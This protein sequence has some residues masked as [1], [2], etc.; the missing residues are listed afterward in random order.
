MIRM[1]KVNEMKPEI[2]F[3]DG[4][5]NSGGAERIF[6]TLV[7]N[8]DR[9]KY[10][11]EVVITGVPGEMVSLLP[12]DIKCHYLNIRRSRYAFFHLGKLL[13]RI[14]PDAVFSVA[15]T[16]MQAAWLARFIFRMKY[17]ITMR[18]CLMPK[19]MIREGFKGSFWEDK[20][21]SFIIRRIECV[22]P[23]HKYMEEELKE[24]VKLPD[25]QL[26]SV[27][28]PLDEPLINSQIQEPFSFPDNQVNVVAA[29]RINKEKGFDF[30]VEA[31]VKVVKKAP[32]F[33]LYIIGKDINNN[34][35]ALEE[36]IRQSGCTDNIHFEG[37]Q[38]NPYKYFKAA[39]LYVLSSRWEASPNVVF[40][41]LYLGQRIVATN[42]SPILKDIL[43]ENGTLVEWGDTDALANAILAYK[44]YKK[45]CKKF[46]SLEEFYNTILG[47]K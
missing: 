34:Q 44:E 2:V 27:L 17:R 43:G 24:V 21:S 3:I 13:K 37:F 25:H 31:F 36:Y 28:N 11:A 16:S 20:I 4:N 6:C 7:R 10:D 41:N 19:Q 38:F 14:K 22:I 30:L 46:Y 40:E 8:I 26:V 32:H 33:H 23:E 15:P 12:E 45:E 39:D 29:G 42:C 9:E 5:L 1:Q 35:A 47:V 18:Y